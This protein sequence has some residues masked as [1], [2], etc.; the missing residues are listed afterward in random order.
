MF[1]LR[2]VPLS[3]SAALCLAGVLRGGGGWGVPAQCL[4]FLCSYLSILLGGRGLRDFLSIQ[5]VIN[6]LY[7]CSKRDT[8]GGKVGGGLSLCTTIPGRLSKEFPALGDQ[9]Q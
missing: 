1:P 8:A 2:S 9:G 5:R 7:D 3:P 4:S 6:H